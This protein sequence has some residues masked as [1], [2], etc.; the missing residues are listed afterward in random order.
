MYLIRSRAVVVATVIICTTAVVAAGGATTVGVASASSSRS[1]ATH[2]AHVVRAGANTPDYGAQYPYTLID[3]GTLGGPNSAP[4]D[5]GIS[6]SPSGVVVGSS[7][8]PALDPFPGDPACLETNPCHKADAFEWRNGVMTDLGALAGYQSGVFEVNASGV[9]V[10]ISETGVLDPLTGSPETHAVIAV[11]SRLIDLGTLGG[12]ESWANSINDEGQVAGWAS[13]TI[14]DSYAHSFTGSAT[15]VRAVI[16]QGGTVRDLGTLGGPDSIGV[17]INN[18]GQVAG[19][20]FTNDTPSPITGIPTQDPFLWENGHMIDLGTLGGDYGGVN[21]MNDSGE[22]VGWSEIAGDA[23]AHP[24]LWNGWRMIDLGT[25]GGA[26]GFANWVNDNGD[27]AGAAELSDGAWNGALWTHGKAIDL[28][29]VDGAPYADADS[30]NDRD[31][32]VG[33]ADDSKFNSLDA[34]LWT[35]GSAYGLNALVAPSPL[36][37]Q[38]AFYI[39]DNGEIACYGSLPNGDTRVAVLVPNSW[40]PLPAASTTAGAPSAAGSGNG[41]ATAFRPA[42]QAAG[43]GNFAFNGLHGLLA[44]QALIGKGM[45]NVSRRSL[46]LTSRS[47]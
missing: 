18:L 24:F 12:N 37:L 13:D 32:V 45:L 10:G 9:G 4:N 8:T 16:W 28:P 29:P 30:L 7:D 21:W 25:L 39:G 2:T 5:P 6:I 36:H 17:F 3:L 35:G 33:S 20:S 47:N 44:K 27:V 41:G 26:G 31:E 15:Q 46:L 11:G 1:V 40:V 23:A 43:R 42:L 19:N 22:V 14:A 34:V 38:E